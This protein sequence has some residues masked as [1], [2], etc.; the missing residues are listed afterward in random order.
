MT[1]EFQSP[2]TGHKPIIQQMLQNLKYDMARP[3]G[4]IQRMNKKED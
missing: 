4:G 3:G 2:K 1:Q